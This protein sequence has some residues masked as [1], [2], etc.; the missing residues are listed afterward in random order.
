MDA[1][2]WA[3]PLALAL[4]ASL[5]GQDPDSKKSQAPA[6]SELERRVAGRVDET[7]AAALVRDL[8]K[9]GPRMGGTVSGRKAVDRLEKDLAALGLKVE[10]HL[11]PK[12]WCHEPTKWSVRASI[13]GEDAPFRLERIWP[14]GFSPA[15]SG[16]AVPLVLGASDTETSPDTALLTDRFPGTRRGNEPAA[17]VLVDGACT[18]DGA[19]PVCRSLRRRDDQS[20]TFGISEPEGARLREALARGAKVT[21]DWSLET[22]IRQA[23]PITVVARLAAREGAP[24]GHLLVCAHGDSDS[25]GPGAND[26]ASGVA[27]V[28]EIARAWTA[29]IEAG[30][31]EPPPR[32]V[33]FAIWGTE[34]AST[35]AYLESDLGAGV[36]AVLNFDQAGYG[37]TGQRLHVEPDDLPGNVGFVRTAAGVLGTFGGTKGFPERWATNKSL[38]GTDSYVFSSSK[39]F[40]EE[41]LP[42]VTMFTSAWGS[43]D[44]HDR[45]EG[46]PGESWTE[47]DRVA[48]DYDRH[49]HS[50]GDTPENTTD[51]E[52]ENMGWCAR[53]GLLTALRWLDEI[54]G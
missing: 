31:L 23:R 35:R 24:P 19:W 53:V 34:I 39:R 2:A 50:A 37:T 29:A 18:I 32:E 54:D 5:A 14:W 42:A 27:I 48:I 11:A 52:P 3:G 21:L 44:E 47:R 15:G 33:R 17:V 12:Q 20:P 45:T 22:T 38:G 43:P 13:A 6:G 4:V 46:M 51:L 16:S 36:F 28:L 1:A 30:D 7:R 25:G 41:K 9:L 10:R 40:R 26:N 8:V 49:Y